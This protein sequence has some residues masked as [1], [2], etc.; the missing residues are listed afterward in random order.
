ML[1]KYNRPVDVAVKDIAIDAEG[2]GFDYRVGQIG[3][4]R[5]QLV[6]AATFLCSPG[7]MPR[8]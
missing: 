6:T 4:C 1:I 7:A 2:L 3:I 8:I 5:Q